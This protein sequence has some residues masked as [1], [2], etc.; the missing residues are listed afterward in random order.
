VQ[1]VDV[2]PEVTFYMPNAFTPNEDTVNDYFVGTGVTRGV[3]NYSLAIWDRYGQKIFETDRIDEPWNGQVGNQGKPAL[4]GLYV[5]V[6]SFT[7]PRGEP[8]EYRG[9]ATLLR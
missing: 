9:Y 8:F 3:T 6:V 2:V 1:Y 7:G 5:Y 4:N